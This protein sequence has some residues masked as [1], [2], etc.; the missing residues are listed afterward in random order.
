MEISSKYCKKCSTQEEDGLREEENGL[1]TVTLER[2]L[3]AVIIEDVPAE[4]CEN[5]GEERCL[6]HYGRI[7]QRC[8]FQVRRFSVH[9]S[10]LRAERRAKTES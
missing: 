7:R 3:T 10:G 2:G 5:Y 4:F 9:R 6:K 8:W 1:T